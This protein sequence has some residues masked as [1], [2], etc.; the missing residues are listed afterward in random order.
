MQAYRDHIKTKTGMNTETKPVGI[1]DIG[2][3]LP[4]ERVCNVARAPE[5]EA[6]E[7]LLR[8]KIGVLRISRKLP[9]HETSDMA[10]FAAQQLFERGAVQPE[11]VDCLIIVTQNPDGHGLPHVS[12]RV[13]GKLG[14]GRH[15][16]A[17]D[18]SL[19]CSGF[20]YGLSVITS[21]MNAQGLKRGLLITADPYSKIVNPLDRN[22]SLLFGD[23]AAATLITDEPVW[24]VGRFDL[25]S[26]GSDYGHIEVQRESGQ[27]FM[28]GRAVLNFSAR[29]VPESIRK[30]MEMN[31]VSLEQ[32]D[33]FVLHQGS[34]HIVTQL[35]KRLEV[36]AD[37]A[38]FMAGDYGN[39]VSSSIPIMMAQGAVDN[40]R[41]VVL[42]GFG[43]GLSWASTVLF[44]NR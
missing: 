19:G 34:R 5:L 20:V 37:K 26:D 40:D 35:G 18:V 10:V 16:A 28:N 31:G 24:R 3:F 14:L 17:F 32:V 2:V 43:V 38:P 12:A 21:L 39:T 15:C 41:I 11:E 30:A 8:E 7:E 25:G 9:E 42:S 1:A 13:H 23:G 29:I 27:L 44:R 6:S 22:T 36:T 4:E 33:R